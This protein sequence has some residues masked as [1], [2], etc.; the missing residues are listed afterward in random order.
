MLQQGETMHDEH[1]VSEF[2]LQI[3]VTKHPCATSAV[4]KMI[5]ENLFSVLLGIPVSSRVK[6]TTL[7]FQLRKC[8]FGRATTV[9]LVME[10][11]GQGSLHAHP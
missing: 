1:T 10:I 2:S 6:K 9:I 11:Q 4:F 8:V 3:F 5:V 7:L